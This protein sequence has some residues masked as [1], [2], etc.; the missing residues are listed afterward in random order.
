MET[1]GRRLAQGD[2]AA[3][4]ELYDACADHCHHYLVTRLGSRDAADEVLQ[5]TFLRLVRHRRKL[6]GVDNLIGYVFLVAR[7]EALRYASRHARTVGKQTTLSP[8]NLFQEAY[9]DDRATR[10][11]ADLV[12]TALAGLSPEQRE[13]VELKIYGG[14][15]FREI[16]DVIGV[17]LQTAATRYRAALE[18]LRVWLK[19]Q[20]S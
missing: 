2:Q 6:A 7:H 15:T 20:L 14:L 16:A 8:E 1:L 13:V 10:E 11:L 19:R 17:P 5:E 12:S 9:G 3:F 18:H 4:A